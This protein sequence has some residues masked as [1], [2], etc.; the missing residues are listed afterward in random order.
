MSSPVRSLVVC[1]AILA[2]CLPATANE[3][4]KADHIRVLLVTGVDDPAHLWKQTAPAIR[5]VLEQDKRLDVR[6]VEDPDFL[7]APSVGD[8][9][10]ILLHFKN[11]T[12]LPHEAE[13]R[14]NLVNFVKQGKGLVVFHFACGAFED[15]PEF[16]NLAGKVWDRKTGHD[17]RGPFTVKIVHPR[18]PIMAGMHD[19][20]ADDE[21]Y[22]CLIGD[23]PVEMLA[24]A[25]S[26]LT[27]TDQPMAFA[28]QFGKGRVF[29]TSLG[30][31]VRAI[32]MPG[33]AELTR[34][35]C[36]WAAGR[37]P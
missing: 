27:G 22:V 13:V 23:R 4:N 1:L 29:H 5:K 16:A 19:F 11:Y 9:D 3:P 36:V 21:L 32:E 2:A 25:R 14:K 15:W 30:H 10:V 7:A 33:V 6:I 20:Q 12:P 24:T 35:G 34:R 17:T 31:D 8:Y 26:K 28:F 18:H 37:Q